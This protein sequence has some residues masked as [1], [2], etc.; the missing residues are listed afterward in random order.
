MRLKKCPPTKLLVALCAAA[1]SAV[2][3]PMP[4]IAQVVP[5]EEAAESGMPAASY[6][7]H[8]NRSFP[9]KLLWGETHLHTALSL[10]A[11]AFG[12]ILGPDDAWRFA[13]GEQV[14]SSS[15]IPVKLSRP[16]DW[17][18]L[19]DHTDLMGFAPDLHSSHFSF[20]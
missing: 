13:K 8:A 14:T 18:V 17:M 3:W 2:L 6:S 19:T 1:G 11:G 9:T 15:G 12:N 10:D 5:T 4:V 16:L 20:S 7:P